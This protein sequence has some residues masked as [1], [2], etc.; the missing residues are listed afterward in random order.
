[1]KIIF[2]CIYEGIFLMLNQLNLVSISITIIK[3]INRKK[4]E[5]NL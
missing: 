3:I 2:G 1:M 5:M 4:V